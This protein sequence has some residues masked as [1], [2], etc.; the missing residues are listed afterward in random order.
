LKLVL[1]LE[2]LE[3]RESP[4]AESQDES[5]QGNHASCQLLDIMEALGQLHLGDGITFSGLGSIPRWET[6]YQSN[7]PKG[8][9]K[10]HLLGFSS[11]LNLVELSKVSLCQVRDESLIFSRLYDYVVNVR[12]CVAPKLRV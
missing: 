1:L 12:F 11:I 2:E 7:F 3:E 5:T 4:D 8:T 6:I 10:V 9:P